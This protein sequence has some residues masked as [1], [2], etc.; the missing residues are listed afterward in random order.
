[1]EGEIIQKFFR[2]YH[3]EEGFFS[4]FIFGELS[5]VWMLMSL[6]KLV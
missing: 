4:H 5:R 1:M 2:I 3:F 6:G